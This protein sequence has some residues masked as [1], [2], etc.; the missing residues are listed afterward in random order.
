MKNQSQ[1]TKHKR[2]FRW[3]AR[4]KFTAGLL[5]VLVLSLAT[6]LAGALAKSNL[7]KQYPAPG[8]LVDVDGYRMHINCIGQGNPT[9]VL[10]AGLNDFSEFWSLV[11]PEVANFSRVCVY[12]RAGYGWSESSPNPRTS[13]IMVTELHT[14]LVNAD[15]LPPFVLV[16][17]SFGGALVRLY[18]HKYPDEVVGMVLVD[19][20]HEDL[21][22]R[23]PEWRAASEQMIT[24]LRTLIP[25]RS[26]GIMALVPKTIPNRGLP[27]DALAQ[28]RAIL[29]TTECL[30]T[31]MAET[32]QFE[33]N[34][35][36]VAEANIA[37]FGNLPLVVISNGLW[38]P[39]SE[40]PG[41]S[42]DENQQSWQALQ[43]ELLTLSSNSKQ[44][45][46][47]QSEHFIQLQQPSLVI[48]AIREVSLAAQK[49]AK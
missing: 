29:A 44:I 21:F 31:S 16:G 42:G 6:I 9:V 23:I 14:L 7:Q 45:V 47:R 20:A 1:P 27:D 19:S 35:A 43:S 18:A 46:A 12:D 17:H 39:L 15:E 4:H 26:T 36:Q 30:E 22:I 34:L 3:W 49:A 10:E 8:Q 40:I 38:K 25:L 32:R 13:E 41:V 2:G 11:Q 48:D 5:L 28:Y 37:G 33:S 24:M